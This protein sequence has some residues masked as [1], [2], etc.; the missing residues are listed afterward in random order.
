MANQ[1][2]GLPEILTEISETQRNIHLIALVDSLDY[3][4]RSGRI[5]TLRASLGSLLRIRLFVRVKDGEVITI[6]FNV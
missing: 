1:S 4:R 2:A 5:S 3:L 6:R